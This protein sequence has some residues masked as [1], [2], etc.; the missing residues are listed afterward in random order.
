MPISEIMF[1]EPDASFL[2][3]VIGILTGASGEQEFEKDRVKQKKI[4]LELD[5]DGVRLE[6][7]FFGKYVAEIMGHLSCGD[8]TNAVVVV[9]YAKIKPFRD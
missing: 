2:I 9:H 4:T 8:M 6:C 7:V 5:Q 3:D 1:I